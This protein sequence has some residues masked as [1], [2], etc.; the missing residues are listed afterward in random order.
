[1]IELFDL[2]WKGRLFVA[3][4]FDVGTGFVLVV[5]IISFFLILASSPVIVIGA[6]PD[7]DNDPDN[8]L[9]P[10]MILLRV[11]LCSATTVVEVAAEAEDD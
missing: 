11:L 7:P 8:D 3:F 9:V 10:R 2:I 1:M 5:V 4:E 6:V